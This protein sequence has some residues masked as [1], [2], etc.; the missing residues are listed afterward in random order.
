MQIIYSL[1]CLFAII[2]L[3]VVLSSMWVVLVAWNDQRLII[4]NTWYDKQ[5]II[6]RKKLRER[7]K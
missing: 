7:Q 6:I 4:Q 1:I 5:M 2:G 3:G